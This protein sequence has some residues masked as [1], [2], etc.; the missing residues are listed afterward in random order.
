MKA[1][2]TSSRKSTSYISGSLAPNDEVEL[3][4]NLFLDPNA[5]LLKQ[6]HHQISGEGHTHEVVLNNEAWARLLKSGQVI[7]RSA[8]GGGASPHSHWVL[9]KIL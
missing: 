4:A 8:M 6:R 3:S 1:S 9:V 7:V 2:A 5:I